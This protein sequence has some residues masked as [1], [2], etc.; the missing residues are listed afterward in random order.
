MAIIKKSLSDQIYD[1]LKMEIITKKI[2]FGS[3]IV[4]RNLQERFQVSSSPI[5]DAINRLYADGLIQSIDNTGALV[6]N[7]DVDFY[8]EVNEILLGITN[9]GIKLAFQ[10]SDHKEVADILKEY[11]SLQKKSIGTEKYFEYDYE[12][13]KVFIV[14]SKNSRL[15]KLYKKFNVLHEVLLRGY[16]EKEVFKMQEHSIEIHE[17]MAEAFSENDLEEC[18]RLNEEH[19]KKAEELFKEVFL[20]IGE[21]AIKTTIDD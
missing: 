21:E 16:Y 13:H 9:T 14:F 11:I 19:Y 2:L 5:R 18:F 17:K 3:K 7:F 1:E 15:K 8:V 4:N 20:R 12:F 10:K 6:V